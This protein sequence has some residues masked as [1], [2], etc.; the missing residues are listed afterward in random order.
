MTKP[1]FLTS[2]PVINHVSL[3]VSSRA[4]AGMIED[5]VVSEIARVVRPMCSDPDHTRH[6]WS[7]LICLKKEEDMFTVLHLC[8]V[9]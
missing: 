4:D 5:E 7:I 1:F 9:L 3:E 8:K 6:T 2:D